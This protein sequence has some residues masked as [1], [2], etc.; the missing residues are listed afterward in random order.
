MIVQ[1]FFFGFH[2]QV[3][4]FY[5]NSMTVFMVECYSKPKA[6]PLEDGAA[7]SVHVLA[8]HFRVLHVINLVRSLGPP[9]QAPNP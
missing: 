8:T 4:R 2:W 6:V 7:S 1:L 5:S 9:R 3:V